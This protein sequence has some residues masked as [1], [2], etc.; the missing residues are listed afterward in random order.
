[1]S[2]EESSSD[3]Y[4]LRMSSLLW[5]T[6]T[7]DVTHAVLA[8]CGPDAFLPKIAVFEGTWRAL[9]VAVTKKQICSP[10]SGRQ[11]LSESTKISKSK[12]S[13]HK[14]FNVG[15]V[16]KWGLYGVGGW[17][18]VAYAVSG[19]Q[20]SPPQRFFWRSSEMCRNRQVCGR[21]PPTI[22]ERTSVEERVAVGIQNICIFGNEGCLIPGASGKKDSLDDNVG[23][24]RVTTLAIG[25]AL[26]RA[27]LRTPGTENTGP[28][29]NPKENHYEEKM[30]VM[31]E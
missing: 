2:D 18:R 14:H 23:F 9:L 26:W 3:S 27:S 24:W 4:C 15:W 12:I 22:S 19:R 13:F 29:K 5:Q 20:L 6:L 31:A 28:E 1:M 21:K 8:A 10:Y 16:S 17:S 11:K 30:A 7:S 25:T